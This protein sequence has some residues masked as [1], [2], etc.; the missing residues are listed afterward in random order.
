MTRADVRRKL[1]GIVEF[2]GVEDFID[3]PVRQYSTG[4]YMRLAFAVAAHVE[5]DV[6][7]V[8]EVLA[9]GDA[10][11]QRRCLGVM[12][13]VGRDGRTVFFVSHNMNAIKTL[14]PRAILLEQGRV[15]ADGETPD[16]VARYLGSSRVSAAEAVWAD[17]ETAPGNELYRLH[18]VRLVSGGDVRQR[19]RADEEFALEIDYWNL[20][21]GARL[22]VTVVVQDANGQPV[23]SSLTNLDEQWHLRRRPAG[24]YRS[25]CVVP[26]QLL[27][28]GRF[29]VS[30]VLW[31]EGYSTSYTET[32]A[33]EFEV[34]EDPSVRGDYVGDWVGVVRPR[35]AWR[36]EQLD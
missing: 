32:S 30:V 25:A 15:V 7:L 8:D 10:E 19:V 5:P 21:D 23:F 27:S 13:E 6:L 4:M 22:G 11:F 20:V 12:G 35:L 17:P 3:A 31:G 14:C 24:L 9:V 1:D 34:E 2:A 36:T 29:S 33:I 18:A 26:A 28:D 16:V